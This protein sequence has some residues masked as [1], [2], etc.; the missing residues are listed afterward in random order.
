VLATHSAVRPE[1]WF[2]VKD[3]E[4]ARTGKA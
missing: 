4:A 1:G 2:K 3:L